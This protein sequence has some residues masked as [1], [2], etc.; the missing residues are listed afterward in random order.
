MRV[1][2]RSRTAAATRRIGATRENRSTRYW[3]EAIP[4]TRATA[5]ATAP[6]IVAA[7]RGSASDTGSSF[8]LERRSDLL[9]ARSS[10]VQLG[11]L[12]GMIA[13]ASQLEQPRELLHGGARQFQSGQRL[14]HEF[15]RR[16]PRRARH[17]GLRRKALE[18][19]VAPDDG[20]PRV[21][22]AEHVVQALF[23]RFAQWLGRGATIP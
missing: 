15:A 11:R 21:G 18:P 16:L 23:D 12:E 4:T 14:E 7:R 13:E 1:T 17:A 6:A 22:L 19:P 3:I 5:S 8:R 20:G 9:E 10:A 2:T